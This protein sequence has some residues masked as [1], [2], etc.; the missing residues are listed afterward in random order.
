MLRENASAPDDRAGKGAALP[1]RQAVCRIARFAVLRD[2][3][4]DGGGG[5]RWSGVTILTIPLT[6]CQTP[7]ASA[8]ELTSMTIVVRREGR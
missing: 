3:G 2:Y 8:L 5:Q 6:K 4:L 1:S 7:S